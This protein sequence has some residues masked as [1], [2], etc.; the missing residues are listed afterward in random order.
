MRLL[1]NFPY[2]GPMSIFPKQSSLYLTL[3]TNR[4]QDAPNKSSGDCLRP[5]PPIHCYLRLHSQIPHLDTQ[6]LQAALHRRLVGIRLYPL[7][8]LISWFLL[9]LLRS[10]SSASWV[11]CIRWALAILWVLQIS[12]TASFGN[13]HMRSCPQVYTHRSA[14]CDLKT[15]CHTSMPSK[16]WYSTF[17]KL[18]KTK[19]LRFHESN[20]AKV[21]LELPE[22]DLRYLL[23]QWTGLA[24]RYLQMNQLTSRNTGWSPI[25][26]ENYRIF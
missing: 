19:I 5:Q 20:Y 14:F 8:C 7:Q 13:Y 24:K 15:T 3:P 2:I 10:W 12:S 21:P 16:S 6:G 23:H 26:H 11:P 18:F 4:R 9:L 17:W 1:S 22:T 25:L